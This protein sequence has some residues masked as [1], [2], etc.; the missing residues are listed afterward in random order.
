MYLLDQVI[1]V[2]LDVLLQTASTL[3]AFE[4][5]PVSN[6]KANNGRPPA[7]YSSKFTQ[8]TKLS[9]N[10]F[11]VTGRRNCSRDYVRVLKSPRPRLESSLEFRGGRMAHPGIDLAC[12]YWTKCISPTESSIFLEVPRG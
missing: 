10:L 12:V 2:I 7:T 3:A 8:K 11:V 6:M 1:L 9:H 5:P 4:V